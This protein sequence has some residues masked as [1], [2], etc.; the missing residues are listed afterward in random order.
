MSETLTIILIIVVNLS[1]SLLNVY[2][3]LKI[4]QLRSILSRIALF[5]DNCETYLQALFYLA[6]QAMYRGKDKINNFRQGYQLLQLRLQ[7]TKQIIILVNWS[8]RSWRS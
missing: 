2:L 6:P 8:Y 4:W 1:I 5:L 7:Q 3:A